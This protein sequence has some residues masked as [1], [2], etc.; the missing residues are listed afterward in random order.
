[1][2][3]RLFSL[4]LALVMALALLPARAASGAP[5]A[6]YRI[7]LRTEAGDETLG[8]GVLFGTKTALLTT[9]GCWA[10]GELYAIGAD[11]EHQITYRGE[12]AGSRLLMLGLATESAAEPLKVTEAAYLQ[13]YMLYGASADGQ[14]IAQEVTLSRATVLNGR[15]EALLTASEGLLP[16]AVMFGADGGVACVTVSQHGEGQG[17]YAAIADVTLTELLGSMTAEDP[18][19]VRGFSVAVENGQMVID[20]SAVRGAVTEETIFNVYTT[21]VTN[22]YLSC[23]QVSG[24]R[25]ATTFPAVPGTQVMVWIVRSE[26]ELTESLFPEDVSDMAVVQIPEAEPFTGCGLRNLR[27][28]VTPGEPGREGTAADFLPQQPLTREA[29]SDRSTPIYF[30]TEDAYEVTQEDDDHV[31]LV[32]FYTPEGYVFSYFSGYIF[33]PEMNG[34]DLWIADI[35]DLFASYEQFAEGELWPAGAY[36]FV[37]YIDGGEV[38]RI[39]FTLD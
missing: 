25:T 34:S 1:M 32:A 39:P 14:F 38:A 26:G 12:V 10:E 3:K 28:G 29:L 4:L 7:V 19:L 36:E 16:G 13:D 15:A 35:S 6:L 21:I 9:S 18:Q 30:Q 20:W 17:I 5:D 22:T 24:S 31:L 23:E 37:Y 27:C 2:M 8:T 33:M 11:G